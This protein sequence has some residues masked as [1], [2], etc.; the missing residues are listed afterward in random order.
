[1]FS[2]IFNWFNINNLLLRVNKVLSLIKYP[3][4]FKLFFHGVVPSF[5]HEKAFNFLSDA[6]SL[7]DCGSNKGQFG[8]L[9]YIL[10]DIKHYFAFDPILKAE[11]TFSFLKARGVQVHF[12]KYALSD[13]NTFSNFYLTKR[14]DSSSLKKPKK[15]LKSIFSDVYLKNIIKVETYPLD[16]FKNIVNS[17]PSP[18]I[19]KIDV[20]GNEYELLKGAKKSLKMFKYIFIECTNK[21]VYENLEF[22]TRDIHRLLIKK[23][24]ELYM[25]YN[26]VKKNKQ[27]IYSDRLYILK[28]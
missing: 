8:L 14:L 7:I 10:L 5:E 9:S 22:Y 19:L 26:F 28:E 16:D 12:K 15:Y 11:K 27:V 3:R 21:D 23:D 2:L 4:I 20:Q 17:L 13:K 18:R 6:K 24:F 1:M 25:E